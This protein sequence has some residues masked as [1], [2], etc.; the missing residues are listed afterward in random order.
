M[1][2][3]VY[4][5]ILVS[6]KAISI[7]A[8]QGKLTLYIHITCIYIYIKIER[9][10]LG[11]REHRHQGALDNMLC[12]NSAT[13]WHGR[14]SLAKSATTRCFT[15][16]WSQYTFRLIMGFWFRN[17]SRQVLSSNK[18]GSTIFF[19]RPKCCELSFSLELRLQNKFVFLVCLTAVKPAETASERR[20]FSLVGGQRHQ[21]CR[22]TSFYEYMDT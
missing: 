12:R 3:N 6:Q 5:N 15:I 20:L 17:I 1:C 16:A 9:E 4:I 18:V 22:V 14:T 21:G 7:F 13:P 11:R 10:L 8:K 2:I 19:G